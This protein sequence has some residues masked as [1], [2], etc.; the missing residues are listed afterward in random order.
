MEEKKKEK[1][2][3]TGRSRKRP[4]SISKGRWLPRGK[5]GGVK[6]SRAFGGGK[7]KKKKEGKGA[8]GSHGGIALLITKKGSAHLLE[9]KRK[10]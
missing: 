1:V 3:G 8:T 7:K 2:L 9:E 10:G 6:S 4:P 5:K